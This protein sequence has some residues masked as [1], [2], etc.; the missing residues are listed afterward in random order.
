MALDERTKH[1]IGMALNEADL[2]GAEVSVP[3]RAAAL[4]FR[5]LQLPE[6]G[7]K[8]PA[9]RRV[10]VVLRPV[11]RVVA[12]LRDASWEDA[13]APAVP[14]GLEDLLAVVESFEGQP[15]YGWEFID[16]E[17]GFAGWA[18]R[19]SLDVRLGDEGHTHSITLFQEAPDRHLDLRLWFD[20]LAVLRA[21]G[22]E[23]PLEEFFAAAARWWDAMRAGDP[24]T[25]GE[26]IQH[27]DW[28]G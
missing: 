24:R 19:L 9:D 16:I 18:D 14:F 5:V 12:S 6:G 26:G 23:V 11:G 17:R 21:D 28:T 25:D 3:H 1:G 20:S 13:T 22:S 8:P 4:T 7:G 27:S 2:L 15:V 10:S